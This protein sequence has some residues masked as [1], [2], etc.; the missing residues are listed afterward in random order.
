MAKPNAGLMKQIVNLL[1]MTSHVNGGAL[2]TTGHKATAP[3]LNSIMQ[4]GYGQ[5]FAPGMSDQD[6]VSEAIRSAREGYALGAGRSTLLHNSGA[7][8][9]PG[10][11]SGNMLQSL[12][13]ERL[14]Q[15]MTHGEAVADIHDELKKE[16]FLLRQADIKAKGNG[17]VDPAVA[18]ALDAR[19]QQKAFGTSGGPGS[20][21]TSPNQAYGTFDPS[22]TANSVAL[23]HYVDQGQKDIQDYATLANAYSGMVPQALQPLYQNEVN[24]RIQEMT[25]NLNLYNTQMQGAPYMQMLRDS[26]KDFA[27][28]AKAGSSSGGTSI[29]DRLNAALGG[30]GQSAASPGGQS[31]SGASKGA[32]DGSALSRQLTN[33]MNYSRQMA[34]AFQKWQTPATKGWDQS[35]YDFVPR[36]KKGYANAPNVVDYLNSVGSGY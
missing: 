27:T 9:K 21:G 34:Q 8:L 5:G 13:V 6:A 7:T 17:T 20:I 26:A 36:N 28:K 14:R 3:I 30:Q 15:G 18:K 1:N 11:A 29:T 33:Q 23:T 31:S 35:L 16:N 4:L 10:T 25:D 32:L 19:R 24:N 22:Q 2:D 12:M